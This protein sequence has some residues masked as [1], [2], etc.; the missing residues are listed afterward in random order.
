MLQINTELKEYR[1]FKKNFEYIMPDIVEQNGKLYCEGLPIH[2]EKG[3]FIGQTEKW[4]DIGYKINCSLSKLLSNLFPY[5][6]EFKGF[7]VQSIESCFQALKFQNPDI[8]K[9][10]FEYSG[11]N[12]Y[13][14]QGASDYHWQESG[15]LYWQGCAIDRYGEEYEAFIDELYISA[16]QNP[17]YRQSLKNANKPLIHSIGKLLK[18]E[19]TFTRY[20]F[21]KQ[22]NSLSAFFKR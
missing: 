1:N 11:V 3:T 8:Q 7:R 17:F 21:E 19:T 20:E 18:S 5:E 2:T 16:A 10:V 12:A 6:F 14:L 22:I 9:L 15:K 13:H 4:I